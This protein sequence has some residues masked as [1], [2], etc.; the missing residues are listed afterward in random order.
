MPDYE[1]DEALDEM[2]ESD[3]GIDEAFDEAARS[4][5][6]PRPPKTA[7]GKGLYAPRPQTQYVTQ[8]QLQTALAKV[9]AQVRTNSTAISQISGRASVAVATAKKE[10]LDR[11]KEITAVKNNLS[12]TQQMAAILP[13]LTQPK[14]VGPV[15][16]LAADGIPDGNKVLVDS[17]STTNLL[18]PL[19]LMTSMGDSSGSGGGG[20]F[21]GGSDNS[22]LLMLALVL[23]LGR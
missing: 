13:L 11:K 16:G 10:S 14:S 20:L 1:A 22:S 23:G 5:S 15:S 3:E 9:G 4:W 2:F 6:R 12:Q 8:A 21:G 19:L 18:L 17:G 7:S